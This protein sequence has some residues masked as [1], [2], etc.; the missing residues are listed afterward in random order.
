MSDTIKEL[1]KQKK[2]VIGAK[3]VVRSLLNATTKLVFIVNTDATMPITKHLISLC[4][5]KNIPH[6]VLPKFQLTYLC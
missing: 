5:Q 1:K 4:R 6:I 2:L 3:D